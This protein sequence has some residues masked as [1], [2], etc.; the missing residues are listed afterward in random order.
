VSSHSGS[1]LVELV[2]ALR[3]QDHGSHLVALGQ[4]DLVDLA[5]A[6]A[7]EEVAEIAHRLSDRRQ[8]IVGYPK[9]RFAHGP[10]DTKKR[11]QI[12]DS[13]SAF[14]PRG[15]GYFSYAPTRAP[16]SH[17]KPAPVLADHRLVRA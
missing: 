13:P 9:V 2:V 11:G 7:I 16:S 10:N 1:G 4:N 6:E 3:G 17:A 12:G 15:V 5:A 14:R 8:L